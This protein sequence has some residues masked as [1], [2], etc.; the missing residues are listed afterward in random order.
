MPE[1]SALEELAQHPEVVLLAA[2]RAHT[3]ESAE[4]AISALGYDGR[5]IE[6]LRRFG[7][8]V[9][10]GPEW[11]LESSLRE[12]VLS[13]HA[14]SERAADPLWV[15]AH[16]HYFSVARTGGS[17]DPLLFLRGMTYYRQ[18]RVVEAVELLRRV[19]RA[20]DQ[21][22][23][24]AI[25]QHLVARMDCE[26]GGADEVAEARKMFKLS[27]ANARSRGDKIHQS[28]AEHSLAIC[29]LSQRRPDTERAV[30]LLESALALTR[31]TGDEWGQAKVL[32]TLGQV[33]SRY[34]KSRGQALQY[35]QRSRDIGTQL[36][37][38]RHV[39]KVDESIARAK[40][41]AAASGAAEG[42]L[43]SKS[44]PRR[45]AR[46]QRRS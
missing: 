35:L 4:R 20:D 29:L 43:K 3:D 33:L 32:H 25:A 44:A 19:S 38:T 9:R 36:G 22:A 41:V 23:E 46:R 21:T 6:T 39:G 24:V 17:E 18:G 13:H 27:L 28:H 15:S 34:P 12:A 30:Q 11:R 2:G 16:Q 40:G 37:F 5:M 45:R 1:L 8:L 7:Y 31:E 26:R 14:A 42:K 10:T